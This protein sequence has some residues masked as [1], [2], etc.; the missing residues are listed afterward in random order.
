MAIGLVTSVIITRSLGPEGRG[1]FTMTLIIGTIGVQIGNLGL[2]GSNTFYVAKNPS[3]LPTLL[4][5]SILISLVLGS[6]LVGAGACFFFFYPDLAPTQGYLLYLGLLWIPPGLAYLLIQ[7]LLIGIQEFH[8]FNKIELITK[9]SLLLLA[10]LIII[11]KIDSVLTFYECTIFTLLLGLTWSLWKF[12]P[13]LSHRIT[14]SLSMFKRGINYGIKSYLSCLFSFLLLK[15]DLLMVN[16][17]LG[18]KETGWYDISVILAEMIYT[19]PIVVFTI[20]FPKLCAMDNIH[21]K[22]AL[23]KS[24]GAVLL[25]AMGSITIAIWL[26]ANP[27]IDVLYGQAFLPAASVFILLMAGKCVVCM[28]QVLG[29]FLASVNVPWTAIPFGFLLVLVNIQLNL[30][31]IEPYGMIG[32]ALASI[33]C[34]SLLIPFHYYYCAKYLRSQNSSS[35]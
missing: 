19:L 16:D 23:T 22:W 33:I 10:G 21:D 34:F 2:H 9:I 17:I 35:L 12:R 7:N 20:L 14:L 13:Y 1:I 8:L 27:M 26:L 30:I 25:V 5:N 3:I 24:V 15:I 6:V 29:T 32:A 4:G 18:K 31:L 28:N 11:L